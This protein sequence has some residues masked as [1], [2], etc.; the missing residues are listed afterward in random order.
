[1]NLIQVKK[2]LCNPIADEMSALG[3]KRTSGGGFDRLLGVMIL[4]LCWA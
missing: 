4:E 3:Q 1:L 2:E